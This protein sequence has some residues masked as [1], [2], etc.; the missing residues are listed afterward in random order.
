MKIT[1]IS[2]VDGELTCLVS[3]HGETIPQLFEMFMNFLRANQ[4]HPD[5]YD[6]ADEDFNT[7]EL[8]ENE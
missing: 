1:F 4:F 5:D 7:S 2:E 8:K 3:G 6:F